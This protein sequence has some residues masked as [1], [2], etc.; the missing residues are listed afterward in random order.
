MTRTGRPMSRPIS[1]AYLERKLRAI[2]GVQGSNPLPDLVDLMGLVV[3][4]QDRPE[5]AAAGGEYL[6]VWH[7]EQT[8]VVGE[9]QYVG[10]RNPPDSGR[11]V[12]ITEVRCQPVESGAATA[13]VRAFMQ[14]VPFDAADLVQQGIIRDFRM[15][16][17]GAL[18]TTA[19]QVVTGSQVASG[20]GAPLFWKLAGHG[21]S[22]DHD[23]A[24]WTEPYIIPP[25]VQVLWFS[26]NANAR[27]DV[28]Q[29]GYERSIEGLWELK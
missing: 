10:V 21:N 28:T 7:G 4:E 24:K 15:N 13:M 26:G 8:P 23:D 3:L 20:S 12:V 22:T 27:I 18:A 5:W 14:A 29:S 2:S 6:A 1:A 19:S 9:F 11:L 17:Q 25:G 16:I